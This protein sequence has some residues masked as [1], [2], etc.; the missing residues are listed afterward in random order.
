MEEYQKDAEYGQKSD[1]VKKLVM[2][3][4]TQK[5]ILKSQKNI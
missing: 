3:S 4:K 1:Y 2:N 5:D